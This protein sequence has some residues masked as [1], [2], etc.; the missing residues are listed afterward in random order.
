MG[1]ASVWRLARIP[2]S[3]LRQDLC[4]GCQVGPRSSG[5]LSRHCIHGESPRGGGGGTSP[6]PCLMRLPLNGFRRPPP[7]PGAF[8]ASS[9]PLEGG[10]QLIGDWPGGRA[11]G[12]RQDFGRVFTSSRGDAP[13]DTVSMGYRPPR[14]GADGGRGGDGSP[15]PC[16]LHLLLNGFRWITPPPGRLAQVWGGQAAHPARKT[17][18][19]L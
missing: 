2:C 11:R 18:R 12:Q 9:R 8:R 10:G 3:G 15:Y 13:P 7:P 17:S 16:L 6:S 1:R 5:L 4:G 14:G 19:D